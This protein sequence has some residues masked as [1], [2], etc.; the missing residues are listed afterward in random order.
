M[1][2][3]T[4]AGVLI[5]LVL[6]FGIVYVFKSSSSDTSTKG[7]GSKNASVQSVPASISGKL[8]FTGL[9]PKSDAEGK[10]VLTV[11]KAGETEFKKIKDLAL[12]DL[13]SWT[14]TGAESDVNY[15]SWAED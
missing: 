11:R 4:W 6:V 5:G 9:K 10:V 13:E 7:D 3:N 14:W 15:D 1:G 12:A 2:R 8:L